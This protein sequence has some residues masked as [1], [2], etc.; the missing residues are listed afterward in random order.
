MQCSAA[1]LVFQFAGRRYILP[2]SSVLRIVL[3]FCVSA[4][5][6]LGRAQGWN[7]NFQSK[8]SMALT[9]GRHDVFSSNAKEARTLE[10]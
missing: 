9:L 2:R 8:D 5:G 6:G 10:P 4:K 3:D 1:L 7:L